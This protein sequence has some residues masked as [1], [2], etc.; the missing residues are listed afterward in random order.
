MIGSCLILIALMGSLLITG[1]IVE[2]LLARSLGATD[3]IICIHYGR[4]IL[5]PLALAAYFIFNFR[6]DVLAQIDDIKTTQ[7]REQI[8]N[9][10]REQ[11]KS[12][13]D[14]NKY[15]RAAAAAAAF[16]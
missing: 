5:T 15:D 10:W 14:S 11:V 8:A 1:S 13:W 12:A 16:C 9:E 6:S 4:L 7:H 2:L 3:W